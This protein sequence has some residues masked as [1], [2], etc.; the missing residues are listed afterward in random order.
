MYTDYCSL[1]GASLFYK[2]LS[3]LCIL[4]Y[5]RA[6]ATIGFLE[7]KYAQIIHYAMLDMNSSSCCISLL[8]SYLALLIYRSNGTVLGGAMQSSQY[9][10]HLQ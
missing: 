6:S 10:C 1:R 9:L 4:W 5:R 7:T 8:G 2:W 3:E